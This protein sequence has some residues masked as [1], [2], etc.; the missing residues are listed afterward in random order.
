MVAIAKQHADVEAELRE[1]RQARRRAFAYVATFAS[2]FL[3]F[4][5][6]RRFDWQGSTELHTLM[7]ALA[8]MLAFIVGMMA[9][10]R[11][12]SKKSNTFLFIGTG[13][14]AT[15]LLD[16]YHAVVTSSVFASSF[17][18]VPASLIPW[19]WVASRLF[20]SVL[21]FVSWWA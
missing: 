21:M 10:V 20:L 19:S 9:L 6:L 1:R 4:F 13:F 15:G 2:L 11:F 5:V 14:L 12:Y 16:G 3:G 17:P 8:A 18:S 7:E